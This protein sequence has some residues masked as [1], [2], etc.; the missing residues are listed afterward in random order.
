MRGT[1][2]AF[3]DGMAKTRGPV[4]VAGKLNMGRPNES[5]GAGSVGSK[6]SMLGEGMRSDGSPVIDDCSIE[7][8]LIEGRVEVVGIVEEDRLSETGVPGG[9]LAGSTLADGSV[10]G[11]ELPDGMLAGSTLAEGRVNVER[12]VGGVWNEG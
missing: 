4:G 8:R 1:V 10:N 2:S 6:M 11:S 12:L 9:M 5:T 3:T 7:D